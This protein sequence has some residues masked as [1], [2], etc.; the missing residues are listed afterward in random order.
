MDVIATH[1]NADFDGLASMVAARKLFPDAKL[2]LPGGGQETVRNFLAVHDLGMAK[3]KDID[4]SQITRLV[5]VDTQEPDRI[6]TLKSCAENPAIEVVVFDHHLEPTSIS[7]DRSKQSVI[8]SVGATTTLLIE[9]LRRR[10]IPVTPFEATV[11][12]LGLYE[13]TGSFTFSSTTSRDFEAGA[14]L[15]A[16]GADLNMV[17]ETLHRPLDPDAVAHGRPLPRRSSRCGA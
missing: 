17:V 11:M 3:V 14:F 8:E 10:H 2:V 7:A 12:A 13:E 6:G 1:S 15:I 4:L 16:A 5:L 9:Q